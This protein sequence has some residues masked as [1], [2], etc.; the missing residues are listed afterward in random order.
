P[1]SSNSH[2]QTTIS[3]AQSGEAEFIHLFLHPHPLKLANEGGSDFRCNCCGKPGH[4]RRY[5]CFTC[6]F[7][8][9]KDECTS[10][11]CQNLYNDGVKYPEDL[12]HKRHR[13]HRLLL[14]NVPSA[15]SSSARCS[16]CLR[17]C[18]E[19]RY[20]CEDCDKDFH[21][22]CLSKSSRPRRAKARHVTHAVGAGLIHVAVAAALASTL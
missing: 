18:R 22:H 10:K 8:V 17:T 9:H 14:Q 13:D 16:R 12:M 20:R 2:P 1:L 4:G 21:A 19:W 7:N 3:M 5:Q 15:S 11:A 6:H